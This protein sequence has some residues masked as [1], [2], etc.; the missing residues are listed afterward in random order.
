[1]LITNTVTTRLSVRQFDSF[2]SCGQRNSGTNTVIA[3]IEE[4]T[5][6]PYKT[7]VGKSD[8]TGPDSTIANESTDSGVWLRKA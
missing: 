5:I 8:H 3:D 6:V 2:K 1:M 4:S 7:H